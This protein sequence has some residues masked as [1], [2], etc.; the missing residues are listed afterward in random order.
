MDPEGEN[1]MHDDDVNDGSMH[2]HDG[3]SSRGCAVCP[4]LR[5]RVPGVERL[6]GC[7]YVQLQLQLQKSSPYMYR[8][9][10]VSG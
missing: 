3:K 7:W 2:E 1:T 4:N 8:S 9:S 6:G 5:G 10:I